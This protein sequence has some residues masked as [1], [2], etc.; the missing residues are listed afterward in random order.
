MFYI[1]AIQNMINNKIY[2]GQT[3]N[4]E[5]RWYCHKNNSFNE[6]TACYNTYI[7]RA[8]RKYGVDSFQF[9]IIENYDNI[10]DCNNA[11]EFWIKFLFSHNSSIGYNIKLGGNNHSMSEATKQKIG[12][13]NSISLKGKK[14]TDKH[15]YNISLSL[16]GK[17]VSQEHRDN[18]SVVLLGNQNCLGREVSPETRNKI[19][20]ANKG[21]KSA[22]G[23]KHNL[24][25]RTNMSHSRLV[26]N[27]S[28]VE[29][30]IKDFD[31]GIKKK[32][33]AIKYGVSKDTITRV[34]N[35]TYFSRV[36]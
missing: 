4:P 3:K 20:A 24:N 9:D 23:V 34:F 16:K 6:K 33:L 21:N 12:V 25:T 14:L 36:K 5:Y 35:A 7:A 22:L 30:I 31:S 1:Y 29:N 27:V 32:D 19:S 10:N 28:D 2:I 18:L 13:A 11:E 8:I 26:L 15:K 17:D